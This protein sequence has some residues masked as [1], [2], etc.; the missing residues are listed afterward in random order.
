MIR[1]RTRFQDTP[2]NGY[3]FVLLHDGRDL[4]GQLSNVG[5]NDGGATL[6]WDPDCDDTIEATLHVDHKH[7]KMFDVGLW[8]RAVSE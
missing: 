8:A 2:G 5:L 1:V 3:C 6:L 7:P 4:R